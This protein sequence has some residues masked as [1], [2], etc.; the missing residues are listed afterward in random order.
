VHSKGLCLGDGG[1]PARRQ[2]H[3]GPETPAETQLSQ[4]KRA[5]WERRFPLR[6]AQRLLWSWTSA[7]QMSNERRAVGCA[8]LPAASAGP[9]NRPVVVA[10]W[11][12]T[13][14]SVLLVG[15]QEETGSKSREK[16]KN[17]RRMGCWQGRSSLPHCQHLSHLGAECS[18][19]GAQPTTC[20]GLLEPGATNDSNKEMRSLGK[21]QKYKR[22]QHLCCF[23]RSPLCFQQHPSK[24]CCIPGAGATAGGAAAPQG[25]ITESQNG[26]GWKGPLW[27]I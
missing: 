5:R 10:R 21:T 27:V 13:A 7:S 14:N 22:L 23:L 3:P 11:V 2:I 26:W 8:F 19:L 18:G 1:S 15:M 4:L 6:G 9:A 12:R 25:R 24:S 17:G 20:T 16:G